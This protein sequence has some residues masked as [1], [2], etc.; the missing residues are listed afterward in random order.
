MVTGTQLLHLGAPW[1]G[2]TYNLRMGGRRWYPKGAYVELAKWWS[3][4]SGGRVRC[5]RCFKVFKV[6]KA[7]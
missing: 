4:D 1:W 3:S 5:L 7:F 2:D 6:F